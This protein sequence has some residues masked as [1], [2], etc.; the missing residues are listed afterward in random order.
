VFRAQPET[1]SDPYQENITVWD[2]ECPNS[3]E[4]RTPVFRVR[5][6]ITDYRFGYST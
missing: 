1:N 3:P 6:A 5:A 4:G 2:N